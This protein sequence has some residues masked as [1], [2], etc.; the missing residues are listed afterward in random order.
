MLSERWPGQTCSMH[1]CRKPSICKTHNVCEARCSEACLHICLF[2]DI[3]FPPLERYST[4]A[5]TWSSSFTAA[6]TVLRTAPVQEP[7]LNDWH[8][9]TAF[10]TAPRGH[11]QC[12]GCS[13]HLP[14]AAP[15]AAFCLQDPPFKPLLPS[16]PL[17]CL[18]PEKLYPAWGRAVWL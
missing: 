14:P 12:R 3:Y 17:H 5:R 15:V 13:V 8:L 9:H 16:L 7:L 6:S 18:N 1:G 4:E 10:S 11:K 2:V